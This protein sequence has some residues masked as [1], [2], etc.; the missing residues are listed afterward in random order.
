MTLSAGRTALVA[1]ASGERD[2]F[3]QGDQARPLQAVRRI[4]AQSLHKPRSGE[5]RVDITKRA[6][7]DQRD[8]DRVEGRGIIVQNLANDTSRIVRR[9]C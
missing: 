5:R 9:L 7:P 3:D 4:A 8:F 6:K 1:A 2:V